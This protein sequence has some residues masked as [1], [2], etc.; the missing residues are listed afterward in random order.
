MG[1]EEYRIPIEIDAPDGEGPAP[2]DDDAEVDID[3]IEV[4]LFLRELEV[5]A[6]TEKR[7]DFGNLYLH[8]NT[9]SSPDIYNHEVKKQ[10]FSFEN[11]GFYRDMNWSISSETSP[12]KFSE[13]GGNLNGGGTKDVDIWL[14]PSGA[15][16]ITPIEGTG[17]LK[18][19]AWKRSDGAIRLTEKASGLNGQVEYSDLNPGNKWSVRGEFWTGGGSG[20]DAFYI[21]T[22]ANGTP[23]SEDDNKGQYSINFDEYQDQIQLMY[24]ANTLDTAPQPGLDNSQWRR[25]AVICNQGVFK[26]YLLV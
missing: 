18:G 1:G 4:T 19:N 15:I 17:V 16:E 13:S 7:F 3:E 12:L 22:H 10:T 23:G 6:P 11:T 8:S 26:I 2:D 20:A 5:T 9:N 25:F 21:Y 24:A 14:E